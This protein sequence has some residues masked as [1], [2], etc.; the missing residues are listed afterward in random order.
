MT[1]DDERKY[2]DRDRRAA[3][4]FADLLDVPTVD[5][6]A[7]ARAAC[8][9]DPA[10]L[11]HVQ[12]LAAAFAQADGF[13]AAPTVDAATVGA[14]IDLDALTAAPVGEKPGDRIGPYKLLEQIGEGRFGVVFKAE[15]ERPVRRHVAV[16]VIKLGM[17]TREVVARFEAERQA[18]AMMDQVYDLNSL[19]TPATRAGWTLTNAYGINDAG[20]IVGE[21]IDPDGVSHALLLTPTTV[22]EPA[23]LSAV[24]VA[25]AALSGRRRRSR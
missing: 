23:A 5:R 9:D 19:V 16:K 14:E 10:L 2:Q 12:V 8:G 15:Q 25:A 13:L 11:A 3:A 20:Q 18:L 1:P 22:P 7:A 6:P 4:V 17:D 21:G 24:T